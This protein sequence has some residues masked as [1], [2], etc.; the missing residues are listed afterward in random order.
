M[1]T[2]LMITYEPGN[3]KPVVVAAVEDR[4]LLEA[5]ARSVIHAKD[6][7]AR[8]LGNADEGLGVVARAEAGRLRNVLEALI[9]E[10]ATV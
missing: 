8:R 4:T 6:D 5:A 7:E 1:K 9:P 10:L 2:K 3:G